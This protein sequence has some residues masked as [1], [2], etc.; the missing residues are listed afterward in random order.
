LSVY[1]AELYK[2]LFK[3]NKYSKWYFN[4][5]N[6]SINR[7]T[8][9]QYTEK[10]H[11]IPKALGGVDSTSNIAILTAKEHF[12]VHHLLVKMVKDKISTDKMW[13]AFFMMH[14]GRDNRVKYARTYEFLIIRMSQNKSE[15]YKG[16]NNHFFG[17]KHSEKTKRKMSNSWNRKSKRN[18]DNTI[19]IFNHPEHGIYKGTRRELCEKFNLNQKSLWKIVH[20]VQKLQEVGIL[21][22]KTI[23]FC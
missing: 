5:I 11:I 20:K 19:Y 17:K 9:L 15:N 16:E 22:G 10:H 6:N 21:Y 18:H 23:R 14:I 8:L 2:D 7:N 1:K 12:I 13:S 4:I 3:I